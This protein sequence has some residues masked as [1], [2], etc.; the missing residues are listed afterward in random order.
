VTSWPLSCKHFVRGLLGCVTAG[1]V[2]I[3]ACS[4]EP[5]QCR[6]VSRSEESIDS[7]EMLAGLPARSTVDQVRSILETAGQS[8]EEESHWNQP[9]E[10]KAAPIDHLTLRAAR[11]LHEGLESEARLSFLNGRLYEVI[12]IP[13]D[14]Q[15]Y[16]KRLKSKLGAPPLPR[17]PVHL[18][19]LGRVEPGV[20]V[21]GRAFVRWYDLGLECKLA[22]WTVDNT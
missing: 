16:L 21:D 14:Y 4:C 12:V 9:S 3:G 8:L 10:T 1:G 5:E 11:F 20:G 19:A 22:D 13:D 17:A 6:G 15:E 7:T 18:G 2:A